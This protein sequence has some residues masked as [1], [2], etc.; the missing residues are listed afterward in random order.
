MWTQPEKQK[1]QLLGDM[2]D[3]TGFLRHLEAIEIHYHV[4][5]VH[6]ITNVLFTGGEII[7]CITVS[8]YWH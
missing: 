2:G 6:I 1:R 5:S 8:W 3:S 4:S 7:C